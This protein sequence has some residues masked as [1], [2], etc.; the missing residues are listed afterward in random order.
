MPGPRCRPPLI[1]ACWREE[2]R[3]SPAAPRVSGAL[4][5]PEIRVNAVLPGP[6]LTPGQRH[7][8]RSWI[9][10]T[11]GQTIL[12]RFGRAEEVAQAVL[13]LASEMSSYV[14]GTSLVVDGGH[15]C[16]V[17]MPAL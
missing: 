13:F 6:I 4:Y 16:A 11:A 14:T 5:G 3:S 15:S 12:G 2:L 10:V 17:Q 9:E 1:A 8:P 7:T